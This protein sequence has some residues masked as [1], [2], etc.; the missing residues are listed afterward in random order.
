MGRFELETIMKL[1]DSSKEMLDTSKLMASTMAGKNML[2]ELT[3]VSSAALEGTDLIQVNNTAFAT[4]RGKDK[5]FN[6]FH[7]VMYNMDVLENLPKNISLY[8]RN[9]Q[10][11]NATKG[12]IDY[13]DDIYTQPFVDV[14]EKNKKSGLKIT[15]GKPAPTRKDLPYRAFITFPI[16]VKD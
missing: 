2:K 12:I 3:H 9:L 14:Y 10:T 6:Q 4:R 16:E 15:I 5:T 1:I 13:L 8:F 11:N 7:A